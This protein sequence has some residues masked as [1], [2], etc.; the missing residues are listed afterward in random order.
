MDHFERNQI[1]DIPILFKWAR[2]IFFFIK[3]KLLDKKDK[4]LPF[5]LDQNRVQF[6]Q[7]SLLVIILPSKI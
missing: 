2:K 5:H 6:I 3:E 4:L 1:K 7:W